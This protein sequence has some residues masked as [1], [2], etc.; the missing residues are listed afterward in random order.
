M[1]RAGQ[2]GCSQNQNH[3]NKQLGFAQKPIWGGGELEA[4]FEPLNGPVT[5]D[6]HAS[7][8]PPCRLMAENCCQTAGRHSTAHRISA[9]HQK[10]AFAGG[11]SRPCHWHREGWRPGQK[12]WISCRGGFLAE[13]SSPSFSPDKSESRARTTIKDFREKPCVRHPFTSIHLLA[14][15]RV[16]FGVLILGRIGQ[17]AK[18]LSSANALRTLSRKVAGR[19]FRGCREQ[20][21]R[22]RHS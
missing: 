13:A 5:S 6:R 14:A 19:D 9:W 18:A 10:T 1:S 3:R 20:Q 15:K 12:I 21:S 4:R 16:G 8:A 11:H 7:E 2:T 22:C 17:P